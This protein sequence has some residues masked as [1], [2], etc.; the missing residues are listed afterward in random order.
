MLF[1]I[2]TGASFSVLNKDVIPVNV[3]LL[4]VDNIDCYSVTGRKT[5][6]DGNI[7]TKI[8]LGE[9]SFQQKFYVSNEFTD[10]FIILGSDFLVNFQC[11]LCYKSMKLNTNKGS[12]G[13]KEG[14][15]ER[16]LP[17]QM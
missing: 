5:K 14:R 8:K 17:P 7:V 1:M 11:N 12:G 16:S 4:K 2:D 10:K 3:P 15:K 6:I 9:I 13:S